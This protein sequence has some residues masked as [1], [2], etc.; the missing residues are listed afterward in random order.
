[1]VAPVVA[2]IVNP[3]LMP[4]LTVGLV[5]VLWLFDRPAKSAA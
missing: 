2:G 5:F 4:V 1:M 3:L